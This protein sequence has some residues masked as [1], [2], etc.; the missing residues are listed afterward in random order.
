MAD[1]AK[2]NDAQ[3]SVILARLCN[4][5]AV[6]AQTKSG[7]WMRVLGDAAGEDLG[8]IFGGGLS[9][10]AQELR[11]SIIPDLY[12]PA[13]MALAWRVLNWVYPWQHPIG[14]DDTQSPEAWHDGTVRWGWAI[15]R[16]IDGSLSPAVAQRSWLDKVLELAIEAGMVTP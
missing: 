1:L 5:Q 10:K 8:V 7:A 16:V 2:L 12:D 14:P 6:N 3:K 4:W 13:N 9:C 11:D 15:E